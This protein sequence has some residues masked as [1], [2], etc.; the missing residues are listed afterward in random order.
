MNLF[1]YTES[2]KGSWKLETILDW[3]FTHLGYKPYER[4][5]LAYVSPVVFEYETENISEADKQFKEKLGKMKN[6]ISVEII[7]LGYEL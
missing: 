6:S 3:R 1:I 7:P 5:T 2:L 4:K